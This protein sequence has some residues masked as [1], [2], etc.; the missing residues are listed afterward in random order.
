M[1]NSTRIGL[2]GG[3]AAMFFITGLY[4]TDPRLLIAGYERW[5]LLMFAGFMLYGLIQKRQNSLS[6]NKL[7]DLLAESSNVDTSKDFA[8]FGELLQIGFQIYAIAFFIKLLFIYFLFNFYD[9]S[10]IEIIKEVSEKLF[11]EHQDFSKDTNEIIQQRLAQFREGSF[12]PQLTDFLGIG[13]ELVL[14]FIMAFVMALFFK[15]EQPEY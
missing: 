10:L 11:L 6:V 12:G 1:T 9:P 14:G 4:L 15:R 8:S 13:V 2:M 5:T 7:E 3:F